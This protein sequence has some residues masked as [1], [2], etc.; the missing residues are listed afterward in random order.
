LKKAIEHFEQAVVFDPNYALAYSYLGFAYA[1][2]VGIDADP[3]QVRVKSKAAALKAVQLAPNLPDGH[4]ALGRVRFLHW[5]WAEAELEWKRA[6]ELNPNFARAHSEYATFLSM[7]GRDEEALGEANRAIELDPLDY[8]SAV[9]L[10]H[11]FWHMR[12]YDDTI[13]AAKKALALDPN[14]IFTHTI[15]AGAY[16]GKGMYKEAIAQ[17]QEGIRVSG[18]DPSVEALLGAA[19]AR[20]GDRVKAEAILAKLRSRPDSLRSTRVNLAVLYDSLGMRD[21]AFAVL[22]KAYTE[23]YVHLGYIRAYPDF[24]GLRPDPRFKDLMRRMGLP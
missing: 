7:M 13:D 15:L 14:F 4:F 22:E 21:E 11:T 23:R 1:W 24:D 18:G 3:E 6:I 12:R 10:A 9:I 20:M 19:Y 16:M 2:V 17:Y 5:E 8:I